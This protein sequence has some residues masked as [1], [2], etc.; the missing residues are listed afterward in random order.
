VYTI[1]RL[2]TARGTLDIDMVLHTDGD[3]PGS[4]WA[5]TAKPGD[6]VGVMGPGGGNPPHA[7]WYVLAGDE[8]AVPVIA[9]LA[10]AAPKGQRII[11]IIEVADAAEEQA[12]SSQADVTMTW[13]HRN[14]ARAGSTDLLEHALRGMDWPT[15]GEGYALV[16]C[17]HRAARAIRRYLLDERGMARSSVNAAG[18]WRF[19][20]NG[21]SGVEQDG[22]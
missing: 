11:A 21:D 16:G 14:G 4:T 6:R 13:L 15:V 18:Y 19:G 7:D 12:I 10:E 22:E 2:D 3:A 17:E 5:E 8:T 1:R 9:R 20:R